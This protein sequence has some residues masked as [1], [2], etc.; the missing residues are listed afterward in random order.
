[1][2]DRD[3]PAASENSSPV[4][5]ELPALERRRWGRTVDGHLET[6]DENRYARGYPLLRRRAKALGRDSHL[7]RRP[8]ERV[9]AE[10]HHHDPIATERRASSA[11]FSLES[12]DRQP[13]FRPSVVAGLDSRKLRGVIDR[14]PRLRAENGGRRQDGHNLTHSRVNNGADCLRLYTTNDSVGYYFSRD[15]RTPSRRVRSS[16]SS[17][18]TTIE[19]TGPRGRGGRRLPHA[20][21]SDALV[22]ARDD[23]APATANGELFPLAGTVVSYERSS[24]RNR[25]RARWQL[26]ARGRRDDRV[27][28]PALRC[29]RKTNATSSGSSPS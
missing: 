20:P 10:R 2:D 1:M 11:D 24:R 22:T 29:A 18:A 19:E 13:R 16:A 3:D 8:R 23:A 25:G 21:R 6:S 5:I 17:P 7:R 27:R 9:R 12:A 4:P 28:A 26:R 15:R 14:S